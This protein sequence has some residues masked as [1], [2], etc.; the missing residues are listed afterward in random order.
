MPG[1]Y[2]NANPGDNSDG[3]L[4]D[5]IREVLAEGSTR[6]DACVGYFNVAGWSQ[7]ANLVDSL[8]ESETQ[9]PVARL[10][11]GMQGRS[12]ADVKIDASTANE[13]TTK[14]I[15]ELRSQ[16]ASTR[17]SSSQEI[18]LRHL[19]N[20][21]RAG[22]VKVCLYLRHPLHAKLYL[23]HRTD[24]VAP[25]CGWVGSSNLTLA[26]LE[27]QGELN[28]DVVDRDA[29][30]KLAGWFE[31]RWADKFTKD[32]SAQLA[33]ALAQSWAGTDEISPYHLYLKMA[34]ELSREARAGLSEFRAP[35]EFDGILLDY[36]V[37]AVQIAAR[38]LQRR[39][40]VLIGDVVGLGKTMIATAL[41]KLLDEDQGADT[42][43]IC[44]KNL[45][46]MWES[47]LSR[48]RVRGAEVLSLSQVTAK[49]G[50]LPRERRF[51]V[52]LI[53]ESHNLRNRERKDY[54]AIREYITENESRCILL[55]ATPYNKSLADLSN[56][57]RL[58]LPDTADL[59]VRPERA[60]RDGAL[61]SYTGS[62]RSLAAFEHGQNLDDWRDLLRLFMVRRTRS[63]IKENY[64]EIDEDDGRP[65]LV[66]GDGQRN[67]FPDRTPHTVS[68]DLPQDDPYRRLLSEQ[69]VDTISDLRL[70]R[71]GLGGYMLPAGA[72]EAAAV[73]VPTKEEKQVVDNLKKAGHRLVGFTKVGFFK[74]L[75]SSG[76]VFLL[77]V[78]R[79]IIR[80]LALLHALEH[81]L[82]VPVVDRGVM[83]D[84]IDVTDEADDADTEARSVR[85]LEE[86]TAAAKGWY[87]SLPATSS[88]S[89]KW[90]RADLFEKRLKD[91]LWADVHA[92]FGILQLAGPWEKE[93]D[94][95]AARLVEELNRLGDEKVLIFTGFADSARYVGTVLAAAG[96]N[97]EVVTGAT[98]NPTEAAWRF[99]PRSNPRKNGQVVLPDEETRVL[100]ATDLMSEG[101]NLQD[102]SH[103]VNWDLPWA[104]IRLIQ[105]AGRVDRIGQLAE[106][107][108]VYSFVPD[109]D[110]ERVIRLRQRIV[111]RLNEN[112]KLVGSDEVFFE[113]STSDPEDIRGLLN[114]DETALAD[115]DR[116][117]DVDLASYA[118]QIWT[119]AVTRDPR[120]AHIIPSLPLAAATAR[121]E[122]S[123]DRIAPGVLTHIR[124]GL[125]HDV[126]M[127]VAETGVILT[128]SP[129]SVLQAAAVPPETQPAARANG[130]HD[131]VAFALTAAST[132]AEA[133][134]GRFG[135]GN[136]IRSR[137]YRL[138]QGSAVAQ[139]D[140]FQDDG[141][142]AV[143][144]AVFEQPLREEA[145]RKIARLLAAGEKDAVRDLC[146]TL[147]AEGR[148]VVRSE[149][150]DEQPAQVICS[151][152]LR[153][154]QEAIE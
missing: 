50:G 146:S 135:G 69:V 26:G 98:E 6:F 125:G 127:H 80:N 111:N 32:V 88:G 154:S 100:V 90:L 133:T 106:Q 99:A 89:R 65:Y 78:E 114:Q 113:E 153:P 12:M 93:H 37:T 131:L 42:L 83:L 112:A 38:H 97:H 109:E 145:Q 58:F 101:H 94:T 21:L 130:H 40:G 77:S 5:A 41:V 23:C 28:V 92:L 57:L 60:L 20:Q 7:L 9:E 143:I 10:L 16:I 122:P 14:A 62:P 121:W 27:R 150:H 24:R 84:V 117:E 120:L 105:R 139:A 59:G 91:D 67:Y 102:A 148:L 152:G 126:L 34:Y 29:T 1:V 33:D 63:F 128:E 4:L 54:K 151:I 142:P 53:D 76:H 18:H 52:V 31:E 51:S 86:L 2:D 64:A 72:L 15:L 46:P 75:E 17:P 115:I 74:R 71:Y 19:E 56:Q 132:Q 22:R 70:P 81:A 140:L 147:H 79:H 107:I 149:S 43:V 85:S 134:T 11:I 118:H 119:S 48:F 141:L 104:V 123:S 87:E 116:A 95:K 144:Q 96:I 129:F 136:T 25:V 30:G 35:K 61:G 45:K 103:I 73:A 66:L 8:P 3:R 55:S 44:P 110:V 49:K 138:L 47:Y 36:Q 108:H 68:L 137:V 13:L 124:T 39:G 82:P